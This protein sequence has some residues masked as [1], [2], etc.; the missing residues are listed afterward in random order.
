MHAEAFIELHEEDLFHKFGREVVRLLQSEHRLFIVTAEPQYLAEAV[1]NMYG[2]NGCIS[3]I[4][5]Q[6]NGK[7]TGS[8]E[9]SLA[10]RTVK[11]AL[12][13]NYEIEYAFGDSDGD[14]DMLDIAK[15]P[16]AISPTES[17]EAI[18]KTRG[19]RVF[20]GNDT[21]G[22]IDNIQKTLLKS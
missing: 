15:Y 8:V 13:D 14:I 7:F 21:E 4:Y 22:I 18:A 17:L 5:T 6:T 3:S 1:G 9:R 2:F 12:I 11:A 19:W 20:K 16:Y 10:H